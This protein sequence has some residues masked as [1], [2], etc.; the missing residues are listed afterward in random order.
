MPDIA[1][2]GAGDNLRR[3]TIRPDDETPAPPVSLAAAAP[4]E[5]AATPEPA[6]EEASAPTPAAPP[7]PKPAVKVAAATRPAPAPKPAAKKPPP[8]KPTPPKREAGWV[9]Q[10][11]SFASKPNAEGLASKVKAAGYPSYLVPLDRD[12]KTLYRVRVGPPDDQR[13]KAEQLAGRL[14][15][16]GYRGQVTRQEAGG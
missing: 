1:P 4:E 6:P 2:P 3:L 12:G 15:R 14:A 8:S 10:L 7:Q 16:A 13:S 9:V 5:P 11:G